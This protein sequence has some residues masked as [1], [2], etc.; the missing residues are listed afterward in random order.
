MKK[1]VIVGLVAAFFSLSSY[2]QSPIPTLKNIEFD[3]P[4]V[5]KSFVRKAR[6]GET[7]YIVFLKDTGEILQKSATIVNDTNKDE[8]KGDDWCLGGINWENVQLSSTTNTLVGDE[9][10]TNQINGLVKIYPITDE[11]WQEAKP[12]ILKKVENAYINFLTNTWTVALRSASIISNDVTITVE[13]TS[14]IQN[15][16]YLLDLREA[17][18]N[19]YYICAGEFD[20]FKAVIISAG[21]VMSKVQTH[22][23]E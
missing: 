14:E 6:S 21:G 20:R 3:Q 10:N 13:S 23:L 4:A 2:S 18:L 1:L 15:I 19:D 9:T 12:I 22:I 8:L 7:T 17:N 11:E 16:S 5:S